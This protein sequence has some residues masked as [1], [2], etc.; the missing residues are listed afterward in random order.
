MH[1]LGRGWTFD[2]I[3][4]QTAIS[5]EFYHTF[6]RAFINFGSTSLYSRFVLTPLY[7]PEARSNM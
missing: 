3:N 4:E 6:L 7:L 2:D 1:Y 5:K